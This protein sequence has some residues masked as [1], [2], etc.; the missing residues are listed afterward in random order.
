MRQHPLQSLLSLLLSRTRNNFSQKEELTPEVA[1]TSD[2]SRRLPDSRTELRYQPNAVTALSAP[3]EGGS[4]DHRWKVVTTWVV[5][6]IILAVGCQSKSEGDPSAPQAEQGPKPAGAKVQR[7]PRET[8]ERLLA[9]LPNDK[10]PK[11]GPDG[12]A[13]RDV[14]NEWLK[15]NVAGKAV[16]VSFLVDDVEILDQ[17]DGTYHA[18]LRVTIDSKRD[19]PASLHEG[20]WGGD[21][22]FE[23]IPYYIEYWG[24]N[25]LWS[26]LSQAEAEKLRALKG[27][28]VEFQCKTNDFEL[29]EGDD[30]NQLKLVVTFAEIKAPEDKPVPPSKTPEAPLVAASAPADEQSR[31]EMPAEG[32]KQDEPA[33]KSTPPSVFASA[34]PPGVLQRQNPSSILDVAWSSDGRHVV[35]FDNGG[36]ATLWD[37]TTRRG[38]DVSPINEGPETAGALRNRNRHVAFSPDGKTLVVGTA[39]KIAVID[40][41]SGRT[42]WETG[43]EF[44]MGP[45]IVDPNV[46]AVAVLTPN[47]DNNYGPTVSVSDVATGTELFSSPPIEERAPRA[48]AP[49]GKL[50]A[51]EDGANR[52]IR[53]FDVTARKELPGVTGVAQAKDME[54]SPDGRRL[55]LPEAGQDSQVWDVSVPTR[56]SL[57]KRTPIAQDG[58]IGKLRTDAKYT[59]LSGDAQT[60]ASWKP[61][62]NTVVL[63]EVSTGATQTT[64]NSG[65]QGEDQSEISCVAL[66]G[67]G[68]RIAIGTV[69]GTIVLRDAGQKTRSVPALATLRFTRPS[70]FQS[71][72]AKLGVPP[73]RVWFS[74]DGKWLITC[75]RITTVWDLPARR[76]HMVLALNDGLEVVS[77]A[78]PD[79][80]NLLKGSG[81]TPVPVP[82]NVSG[83]LLRGRT[84]TVSTYSP[85]MALGRGIAWNYDLTDL[86]HRLDYNDPLSYGIKSSPDGRYAASWQY[87]RPDVNNQ[88]SDYYPELVVLDGQSG[89]VKKSLGKFSTGPNW[90]LNAKFKLAFSADGKIVAAEV[91]GEPGQTSGPAKIKIWNWET[92]QEIPTTAQ[93]P[94]QFLDLVD[95][96]RLLVTGIERSSTFVFYEVQT[97]TLHHE[98]DPSLGHAVRVTAL[99]F[100]PSG[101]VF[102]TGDEQGILLIRDLATGAERARVQAHGKSITAIGFSS[103]VQQ[104]ATCAADG[105]VKLWSLNELL[106]TR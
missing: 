104:L 20:V 99:A 42:R 83:W 106:G 28:K 50:L 4:Q 38:Q 71:S 70:L 100:A 30:A 26:G 33:A 105:E 67:N 13:E 31:R 44:G 41:P 3:V 12:Q 95:S 75:G 66:N 10:Y 14:A 53:L 23:G 82:L 92:G 91:H 54:F 16:D 60:I 56:P 102:A 76:Q 98:L 9:S 79:V 62:G 96:G 64:L 5:I 6:S 39:W 18:N 19:G 46:N 34:G 93:A 2:G 17:G 55:L 80:S 97:G 85:H 90:E 8:P 27:K 37:V 72:D 77:N 87:K 40:L 89:K 101:P 58:L 86:K 45:L 94:I 73:E 15:A 52:K 7:A 78:S 36:L 63:L 48:L 35:A 1:S 47:P 103:N 61:E 51:I 84:L 11:A 57:V 59:A 88:G 21:F 22:K 32:E 29:Q 68:S 74:P 43:A 69:T 81:D 24:E 65:A 25:P 49:N